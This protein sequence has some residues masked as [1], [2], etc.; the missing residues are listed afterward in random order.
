M[1]LVVFDAFGA[2]E[3]FAAPCACRADLIVVVAEAIMILA[4]L[5]RTV[6]SG[7]RLVDQP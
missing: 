1:G 4:V 6:V 7:L 5:S 2:A 3:D